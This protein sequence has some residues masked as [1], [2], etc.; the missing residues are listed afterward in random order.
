MKYFTSAILLLITASIAVNV[1]AI[2]TG[3][4]FDRIVFVVFENTGYSQALA[5]PYFK[6]LTSRS[7]GLLL[8]NYFAVA[9]PSQPNYIATIF[10]STAGITDDN[11]H[12]V[13][14]NN[15]VDLLEAKGVS[16]KAYMENYPGSCYT[17]ATAP[18]GSHL[19]ARKHNP[20]I[21]MDDIRTNSARCAKIVPGTQLDTD[22][23]NNAV[24]QYV[25]YVPNQNNDG[26][27]TGVTFAS[28][29]FKGWLEPK[30]T[31]PAF[32]TNTLILFTFDEDDGTQG[33]HVFA[34]LLGTPVKPP[35]NHDDTT[36]YKHYS[37]LATVEKNWNLGNLGR[38]DVGATPFTKY[39]V[40]P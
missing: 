28:N 21:S 11:N 3:T 5:D 18:T 6:N 31:K 22:I 35:T 14:G 40:H 9:H 37:F 25:Y 2:V 7:N 38:N 26:H 12:N 33:N 34:G 39:L 24:P 16:W 4:Y 19:Y 29:W 17:G 13:A 15:I 10:G 32:T 23:N 30:L 8:S 20:F 1:N 27:D 36:A